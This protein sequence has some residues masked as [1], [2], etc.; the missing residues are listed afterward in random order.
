MSFFRNFPL[1][2]YKFGDETSNTIFQNLTTYIDLIDQV[3]DDVSF[4]EKY[5]IKDN[6][7]PDVLSYE[8][9]GTTDLYWTFYLLNTKLRLQGWPLNSHEV[10]DWAK[11]I[12]PNR[13]IKT[14]A[15]M[16]GEFYIGDIVADRNNLD[17]FGTTF[18]AKILDKSYDLGQIVVEPII[19][20]KSIT[21]TEAGSGYTSPPT[22]TI[23]GGGGTGATAQ[24][25]MTFLNADEEVETSESI[26]SIAILNGG[27]GYTRIPEVVISEPDRPNGTQATATAQ[28][29]GFSLPRNTTIYTQANQPNPLLWDDDLVRSL[30][31]TNSVLQYNAAHHYN[32]ADGNF[33]DLTISSNGGVENRDGVVPFTAVSNLENLINLNEDLRNIKIF[34]P[35]VASQVNAEFQKLLRN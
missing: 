19:D 3:A 8:L 6:T 31:T 12:Y 7:R 1:I 9:Y 2:D 27:Q 10:Y 28:I 34:R 25:V 15:P 30:I 17:E 26:Q 4:Y 5:Y 18:K 24:A 13:V 20:V 23:K 32:D 11:K 16:W 14:T 35:N 21:L 22:V 33:T 29:S